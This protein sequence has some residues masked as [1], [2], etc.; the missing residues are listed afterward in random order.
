MHAR[1]TSLTVPPSVRLTAF[2]SASCAWAQHQRRFGPRGPF[3]DEGGGARRTPRIRSN[4]LAVSAPRRRERPG[5]ASRPRAARTASPTPAAERPRE[6][7]QVAGR[8]ARPDAGRSAGREPRGSV[9]SIT[10]SR[11]LAETP[12]TMQWWVLETS[13]QGA[14]RSARWTRSTTHISHSGLVRSSCWDITRPTSRCSSCSPPGGGQRAAA[15]VVLDVEVRVLDPH[16]TPDAER[17]EADELAVA[18][19]EGQLGEHHLVQLLGAGR[20][21]LEERD[22]PDVHVADAVLDSE[23]ARVECAQALAP[24]RRGPGAVRDLRLGGSGRRTRLCQQFGGR[25]AHRREH[26]LEVRH[27]VAIGDDAEE[28]VAVVA[29]DRHA[30]G[31]FGRQRH[32]RVDLAQRRPARIEGLLGPGTLVI[33]TLNSRVAYSARASAVWMIGGAS[34]ASP[35]TASVPCGLPAVGLQRRGAGDRF[36]VALERPGLGDRHSMNSEEILLPSAS[37]LG[38]QAHVHRHHR[39]QAPRPAACSPRRLQQRAQATR[40]DRQHDVVDRAP[41]RAP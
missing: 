8:G 33:V 29:D 23:E 24:H 6:Q 3:S 9:S 36:E 30:D 1:T 32:Q 19:D 10:L 13:A 14:S 38:G 2:T 27:R 5:A 11:S 21:A 31:V 7:L 34:P 12:S 15:Q 35:I 25:F 4:P 41:E 28:E 37:L 26:H 20:R 16:R 39:A 17:D 18:R 22:R 40:A